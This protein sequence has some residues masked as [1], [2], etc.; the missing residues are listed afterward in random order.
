[1]ET[2]YKKNIALKIN[3]SELMKD[4]WSLWFVSRTFSHYALSLMRE[5]RKN[6]KLN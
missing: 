4:P 1:M 5:V 2:S 3:G 6:G